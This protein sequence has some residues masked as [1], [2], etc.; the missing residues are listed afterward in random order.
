ML[1]GVKYVLSAQI[2]SVY[3]VLC[4]QGQKYT[5]LNSLFT[6]VHTQLPGRYGFLIKDQV[7]I[8]PIAQCV[9]ACVCVYCLCEVR[10]R[11]I[12]PLLI[13]AAC[14]P[15]LIANANRIGARPDPVTRLISGTDTN[16]H[17]HIYVHTRLH[18]FSS[19]DG[20][21][22]RGRE[23]EKCWLEEKKIMLPQSMF[24]IFQPT[25]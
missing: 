24:L 9:H 5:S 18:T 21:K 4:V 22:T 10:R 19:T 25:H 17:T 16:T 3:S 7:V 8:L 14:Q 11:G 13:I 12:S 23:R 2:R 6:H 15:V 20:G 1:V